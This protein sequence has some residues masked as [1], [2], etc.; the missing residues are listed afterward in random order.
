[1]DWSRRSNGLATKTEEKEGALSWDG[2]MELAIMLK[3]LRK[4]TG[5]T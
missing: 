1:M 2:K 3:L 4:G 5:E